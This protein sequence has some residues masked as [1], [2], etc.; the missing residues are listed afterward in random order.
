LW[1]IGD[2]TV[3]PPHK[4]KMTANDTVINRIPCDLT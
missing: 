1:M 2:R 3:S 4:R